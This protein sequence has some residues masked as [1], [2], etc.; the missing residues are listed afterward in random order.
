MVLHRLA[1][2]RDRPVD[3]RLRHVVVLAP[4]ETLAMSHHRHRSS[5]NNPLAEFHKLPSS[6]AK[7][8]NTV[9]AQI[10]LIN[11]RLMSVP[12]DH[13]GGIWPL[14][15]V[16]Q[17]LTVHRR[18]NIRVRVLQPHQD[19]SISRLQLNKWLINPNLSCKVRCNKLHMVAD[20][21]RYI[22]NNEDL[23]LADKPLDLMVSL[24]PAQECLRARVNLSLET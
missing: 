7:L 17:G 9:I 13:K 20:L 10:Q 16:L 23:F 24:H 18:H 1:I 3:P 5:D 15:P 11:L 8:A 12:M 19:K 4:Q 14:H 2:N 6:M 22:P 21:L